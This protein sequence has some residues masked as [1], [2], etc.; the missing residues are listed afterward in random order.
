MES[1]RCSHR[2]AAAAQFIVPD[3]PAP[4]WVKACASTRLGGV[5]ASPYASFNLAHHVG[6]TAV[7]VAA[8]RAQLMEALNLP[9]PPVWLNQVHSARAVDVC[10]IEDDA[11]AAY[12]DRPGKVCAVLTADCLPILLCDRAGTQ[13]AAV[14][15]GWRGL[16]AGVI[17]T[18]LD[19]MPRPATEWLA[20]L[21]PAIGPD[22]F[23][24]GIEVR[25]IFISHD[26]AAAAAFRPA[27]AGH[28]RANIYELARQRLRTKDVREIYGGGW[29]TAR[30]GARFY[31]YRRE[32]VTG[33]MASLI[34]IV[35][36]DS[37]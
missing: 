11:D 21:G 35:P 33:R 20:W 32:G 34:W 1:D 27:R 13:V 23:E 26:R 15:A 6:D 8:N 30:D 25:D 3:W 14:H 4:A 5:S 37:V 10:R 16:A 2:S 17:E 28:W 19:A 18:T 22:A 29:C 36:P 24:V 9:E 7:A 31:S 12:T